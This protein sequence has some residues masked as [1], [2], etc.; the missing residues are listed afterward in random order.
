VADAGYD[1]YENLEWL[2]QHNY[3]SCIKPRD[4]EKAKHRAWHADISKARNMEYILT[5][6]AFIC[7]NGRKL[8]YAYTR[9]KTSK[10]GFKY[11]SKVYICESCDNCGL[12]TD[13]QR[14]V[15]N[16]ETAGPKRIETTPKYDALLGD[17]TARMASDEGI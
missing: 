8:N 3:L 9:K 11:E 6:D 5:N 17:N 7:A 13:C 2:A 15:K 12:R 4:Y 10:S 14:Y 1:S 16:L